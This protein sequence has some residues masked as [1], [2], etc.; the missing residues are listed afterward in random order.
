MND[1][2][3]QSRA[4]FKRCPRC[5][6]ALRGLPADHA[7]PECGLRYDPES[8]VYRPKNPWA[9]TI[10]MVVALFAGWPSAKNIPHIF[11]WDSASIFERVVAILGC[12]WLVVA[13]SGLIFVWRKFR[14]DPLVAIIPDGLFIAL[15]SSTDQFVPWPEVRSAEVR[16]GRHNDKSQIVFV[17]RADGGKLALGGLPDIFPNRFTANEFVARINTRVEN[18]SPAAGAPADNQRTAG[19]HSAQL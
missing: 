1:T 9:A 19:V 4:P 13:V 11:D 8:R 16:P 17:H 6:Y 15:G 7:C 10:V 18:A 2:A 12:V 3:P 14:R 5:A